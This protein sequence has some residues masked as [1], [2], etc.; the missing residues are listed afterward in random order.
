MLFNPTYAHLAA[1]EQ[2]GF[3]YALILPV[4]VVFLAIYVLFIR[5]PRKSTK[6]HRLID[7]AKTKLQ[8][9]LRI[10]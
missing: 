4:V 3:D 8:K 7:L 2:V 10:G 9:Y 6:E 1:G 5:S